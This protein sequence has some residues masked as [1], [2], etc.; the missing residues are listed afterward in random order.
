VATAAASARQGF[1]GPGFPSALQA[2]S[3]MGPSSASIF[4]G[5]ASSRIEMG[6]AG[7]SSRVLG[8]RILAPICRWANASMGRSAAPI[9]IGG[10]MP[11]APAC[12]SRRRDPARRCDLQLSGGRGLGADLGLQRTNCSPRTS[13]CSIR[14]ASA[15]GY[16]SPLIGTSPGI[17]NMSASSRAANRRQSDWPLA[18]PV[19]F[20]QAVASGGGLGWG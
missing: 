9:T 4:S 14:C 3:T 11:T 5:P 19:P 6:R 10:S 2:N 15:R 12:T 1:T 17:S 18:P 20:P 8:A 13:R 7:R 16:W